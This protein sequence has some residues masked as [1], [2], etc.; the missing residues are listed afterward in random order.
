MTAW[1]IQNDVSRILEE[2]PQ[3]RWQSL[4]GSKLLITGGTG[5]IGRWLV[6]TLIYAN[7]LLS[8]NLSITIISRRPDAF[9]K[10]NQNLFANGNL[11]VVSLD[12]SKNSPSGE[13]THIIHAA[14]DASTPLNNAQTLSMF[15]TIVHGTEKILDLAKTSNG[16]KVLFLS[17]GAVYGQQPDNLPAIPESWTGK[18]NALVPKNVYGEAKRA[19]ELL[20]A[21]YKNE[22]GV[23]ITVARI[24]S[25]LGP[26]LSLNT[27]FAA[28]N[29]IRDAL[30]GQQIIVQGDGR[31][32]RSYLYPSDVVAWLLTLLTQ[33]PRENTYNIGS[34]HSISIAELAHLVARL[35]GKNGYKILGRADSN[36]N[37]GRYVPDN[38]LIRNEFGLSETQTIE[39]A[40]LKTAAANS[41]FNKSCLI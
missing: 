3:I 9:Q 37:A 23:N 14:A 19:A 25:L 39:Q 13:F 27:H 28:G 1:T 12:I 16:A 32:I 31:P 15:Q 20:C 11:A 2:T 21:I 41:I 30:A 6:E 24:F 4:R 36:R 29:F 5:F 10:N 40:I 26:L 7:Q 22:L 34:A 17:S 8:L 18:S 35:V 33:E 38:T